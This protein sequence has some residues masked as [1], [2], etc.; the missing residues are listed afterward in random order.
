[1]E[2]F[3]NKIRRPLITDQQKLSEQLNTN[4]FINKHK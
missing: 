1:M 2:K 4:V 3:I